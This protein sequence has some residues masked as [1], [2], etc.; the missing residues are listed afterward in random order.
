MVKL[1]SRQKVKYDMVFQ[2][3]TDAFVTEVIKTVFF[4]LQRIDFS[5]PFLHVDLTPWQSYIVFKCSTEIKDAL[6]QSIELLC[7]NHLV[8]ASSILA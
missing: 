4:T 1:R 8:T 2:E 5:V 6:S 7:N 3:D